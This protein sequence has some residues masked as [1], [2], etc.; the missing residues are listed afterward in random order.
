MTSRQLIF[1]EFSTHNSVISVTA[2]I[3][4]GPNLA[5]P[6]LFQAPPLLKSRNQVVQLP[7]TLLFQPPHHS[8][9]EHIF[10]FHIKAWIK[11]SNAW[12]YCFT[13]EALTVQKRIA[14][15]QGTYRSSFMSKKWFYSLVRLFWFFYFLIRNL[16]HFFSSFYC[17]N[18]NNSQNI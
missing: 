17:C 10:D 2:F 13:L 7:Q 16:I 3:K 11:L 6:H 14:N 9:L 15:K 5:P 18:C 12:A 8:K 1:W 4:N